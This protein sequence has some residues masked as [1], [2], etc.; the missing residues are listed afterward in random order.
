[1]ADR[2]LAIISLV[3]A[4][5]IAP[6][7][8]ILG[9]IALV[10]H[11]EGRGLAI[12]AV[13]IGAIGTLALPMLMFI[14]SMAY[15]GVLNPESFI[16]EKCTFAAGLSCTD[17]T[18]DG[19][20]FELLITNGLG[21]G[22]EISEARFTS[23]DLAGTCETVYDEPLIVRNG[24]TFTIRADGPGCASQEETIRTAVEIDYVLADGLSTT[25]TIMGEI[26]VESS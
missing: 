1:M 26:F 22:I 19:D 20:G 9:I 2:T 14:G 8:L 12:A 21:R 18:Y 6:V 16:P 11:A 3:L 7:G 24:E 17:Y 13:V 5:L 10:K 15:Y 23:E 4:I 25:R